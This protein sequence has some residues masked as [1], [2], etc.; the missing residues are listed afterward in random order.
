MVDLLVC[1]V[2]AVSTP[3]S[4]LAAI[5]VDGFGAKVGKSVRI[6]NTAKIYYP[7]NLI[8]KDNCLIGPHVDLYCV[9]PITIGENS[10]VSQY[11]YLC[12]A[13]HDHNQAHLPLIAEPITVESGSWVCARAFLGPGVTVGKNS[14]VAAC[15]VVVKDV[16]DNKIVGGNPAKL[17]KDREPRGSAN[18]QN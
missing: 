4:W 3:V 12:A 15:S 6:Y 17:I 14:L 7:P 2:F 13:S 11:S 16:P 9:A 18:E 10:M 5:C 8:L 1:F